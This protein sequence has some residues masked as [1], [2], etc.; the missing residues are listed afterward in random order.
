MSETGLE[1]KPARFVLTMHAVFT[2]GFLF[3]NEYLPFEVQWLPF[4]SSRTCHGKNDP[5]E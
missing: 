2:R 5:K 4:S 1:H 3:N